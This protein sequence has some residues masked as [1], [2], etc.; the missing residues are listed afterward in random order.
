[1]NQQ[2]QSQQHQSS[3]G[4]SVKEEEM[5]AL[6]Q[7][8]QLKSS[9][10]NNS[11]TS[12]NTSSVNKK[13]LNKKKVTNNKKNKKKKNQTTLSFNEF[14]ENIQQQ[15]QFIPTE[16]LLEEEE[17]LQQLGQQQ[18]L[19]NYDI[20][21][22]DIE[23]QLLIL[24]QIEQEKLTQ[25][26]L[27]D[28]NFAKLLQEEENL[29]SATVIGE[30]EEEEDNDVN[31]ILDLELESAMDSSKNLEIISNANSTGLGG[32][33]IDAL[34]RADTKIKEF[35][36]KDVS[37]LAY[38]S[39]R[40]KKE[41]I[42]RI[43]QVDKQDKST[44]DKV[45]D[46]R[47]QLIL[48]KLI[49]NGILR[50][51]SGTISTGKE[52]HVFHAVGPKFV[53]LNNNKKGQV[54]G[55]VINETSDIINSNEVDDNKKVTFQVEDD[56]KEEEQDFCI[57]VFKTIGMSFRKREEYQ[58]SE[59]RFKEKLK[60]N[61]Q[62][63]VKKYAEKEMRNLKK[64]V[65]ANIPC[66]QP[67]LLKDHILL[68]SFIGKN[69]FSAPSL[70]E[71]D[72]QSLDKLQD[73][74]IQVITNMRK[75]YQKAHLIHSDLS[76]YNILYFKNKIYFIDVSQSVESHHTNAKQFLRNDC[77]HVN[78][79]FKRQGLVNILTDKELF[80]YVIN[81][82]KE[83]SED[84]LLKYTLDCT[85]HRD[86]TTIDQS[87]DDDYFSQ[88]FLPESTLGFDD[89]DSNVV[90]SHNS[91]YEKEEDEEEEVGNEEPITEEFI[92]ITDI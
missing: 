56:N 89:M 75:M 12:S 21:N 70:K 59:H 4:N 52:S 73:I 86:I 27:E 55:D 91:Q 33:R 44:F 60:T 83:E 92:Y 50:K 79:Y 11:T 57:K 5:L 87:I 67:Y 72:I 40:N 10:N 9:N 88:V 38:S 76:E 31:N 2:E 13:E 74:Y 54:T 68:M 63:N 29:Q 15:Q 45:L 20:D 23:Q 6:D 66:P 90:I 25:Q 30:E 7:F 39:R 69:G 46:Q 1:M 62:K 34:M 78:D 22:I 28:E 81:D 58:N 26:H 49:N 82:N 77:K 19:E 3:S 18:Q 65:E 43:R 80:E 71:I 47:T 84:E 85:L 64:L 24:Q 8:P 37:A 42:Q 36:L 61:S 17:D 35:K 41:T 16:F 48:Y 14:T 53:I 32:D 51:I